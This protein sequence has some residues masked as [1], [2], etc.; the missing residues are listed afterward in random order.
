MRG[1]TINYI[2]IGYSYNYKTKIADK[3]WVV[4][5]KEQENITNLRQPN[6]NYTGKKSNSQCIKTRKQ[7]IRWLLIKT[8]MPKTHYTNKMQP[9][10][11]KKH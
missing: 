8:A 5:D 2:L 4:F 3:V 1:G 9:N 7:T 10:Q 11:N 6:N